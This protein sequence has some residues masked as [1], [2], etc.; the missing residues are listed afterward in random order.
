M[1]NLKMYFLVRDDVPI[2]LAMNAV[3]HA[4]AAGVLKWL[5]AE[6]PT[7]DPVM[8][9]WLLSFR[10]VV[11]KVTP[12][13]FDAAK[14]FTDYIELTESALKGAPTCLVFKPRAEWPEQFKYYKLY[15]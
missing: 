4:S 6:D 7:R 1:S 9:E 10:K 15:K 8:L 13:E 5:N 12:E 2:G 11:C 3:A 14:K